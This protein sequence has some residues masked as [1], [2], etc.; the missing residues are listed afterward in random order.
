MIIIGMVL[1]SKVGQVVVV[2]GLACYVLASVLAIFRCVKVMTSGANKR[3]PE[4]RSAFANAIFMG[5]ILVIAVFALLMGV[6]WYF[7]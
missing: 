4:Y 3:S 5:I 2:A 6:F 7:G 1:S